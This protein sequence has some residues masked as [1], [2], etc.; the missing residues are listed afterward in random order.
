MARI[1]RLAAV[2]GVAALAGSLV[3]G[4]ARADSPEVFQGSAAGTALDLAILGKQVTLGASAAKADSA[5]N[6]EAK[7]TGILSST[8]PAVDNALNLKSTQKVATA[9]NGS[10]D[11]K[12]K[13]CGTGIA[14]LDAVSLG[15]A[16]SAAAAKSGPAPAATGEGSV[17]EAGVDA[18]TVIETLIETVESTTRQQVPVDVEQQLLTIGNTVAGLLDPV[19]AAT[20]STNS[21]VCDAQTTV[22]DLLHSVLKTKTLE[23]GVGSTT[24]SVDTTAATVTSKASASGAV[25]KL[26]PLP[27]V[28]GLPST[29]PVVTITVGEANASATYDRA[30]GGAT[31]TA[32][33]AIVRISFNT[34]LT[35]SL[36]RQLGQ[37]LDALLPDGVTLTDIV[38]KPSTLLDVQKVI[39]SGVPT[40]IEPCE[41]GKAICILRGTPL[42]S[43]IWLASSNVKTNPDGS[44]VATAD[45]VRMELATG[46]RFD[47]LLNTVN[48]AT[49]L[50]LKGPG[51][52]LALAGVEAGVGG[53]PAQVTPPPT[54]PTF[55]PEQSRTLPPAELP[56]TGGTPWVPMI[57]ATALALA[58]IGRRA[59]A[60]ATR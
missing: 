32:D 6:V 47:E 42:E 34:V 18:S 1:R 11:V 4:P 50:G 44:V 13:S 3:G 48:G 29:E 55:T 40:L 15:L 16:C 28:N 24:S 58:V 56:R 53:R 19:C 23:V 22:K 45:A 9:A 17:V 37:Q 43:K 5:G 2:V 10:S 20:R 31:G 38:I 39:G 54:T 14:V 57:G 25:V 46:V 33:P 30:K 7:G 26:L 36:Q 59:A 52:R 49:N 27:Q 41:G 21:T 8:V 51:V 35:D 60:K 12:P